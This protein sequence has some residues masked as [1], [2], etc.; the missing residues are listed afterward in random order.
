MPAR[1]PLAWLMRAVALALPALLAACGPARNEFPP[2]C[3]RPAILA[4][5]ADFDR[6]RG[7]GA[8]PHDLT[9]LELHGHIVGVKGS[10][11]LPGGQR[12]L[13]VSVSVIV[14]LTRGPAMQG[15]SAEVNYFVTELQGN[16]IIDK[17]S[18]V[19]TVAFPP[20]VD[21]MTLQSGDLNL[22]LPITPEKTGASYTV[23]VG[24]QLTPAEMETNLRRQQH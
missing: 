1:P 24:F 3:P 8:G 15:R 7:D 13:S 19:S 11:M 22:A 16:D 21:R 5:A 10:C 17:Q 6:Y 20:N 2:T 4:E 9:E 23:L 12:A 18:L 14:E